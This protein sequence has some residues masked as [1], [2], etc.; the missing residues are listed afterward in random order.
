MSY[1][2]W[3]EHK[4]LID[5]AK[6]SVKLTTPDRKEVEFVAEPVVTAKGIAN[7]VKINQLGASQ[8]LE[9]LVVNEFPDVFPE[10]LPGMPPDRDIEFVIEL[11]PGTVPIYN[12]PFRMTI[13]ELAKLKEHIREL[14][15]K[16][17]IR[18]NSS[19]WGAPLIFVPMKD[20]TQ[21]LCVDYRA[22]N[23]V[24]VKNKYLLPRIDDLFDQLRGACVFSKINLRSGYH[25]LKVRECDIPKIAFVSRYGL[26]EFTVMSFGL[27]NASAYF[28]Y[29]MNKVFMVYLDKFI[30]VFINDIPVYSRNEEEHEGHLRLDLQKL[31]DHKLYAKLSKCEFWLKQV[32]F[33]GHVVLKGGISV[34]PSK[35]QDVLSWKAP[36]SVSDIRS[37]LGLAE[38]YQRFIEG[39]SRISKPMTELLKKDKQFKWTPTCEYSFQELKKRLTTAPVLVMPNMQDGRVVA[40]ASRQLRKHE[41]NYPTHDLEL[42][43][44][45]H[46]L[47][48]WRHYLMGKRCE[49]YMDHQSLKYI[50]TLSNLNL[51]QRR[52]LELIKDYD[53]GINYHLGKANV[54][55]DTLSRR[56]HVS[57]LVVDRMPFQ[58][59]EEFD[60]LNLRIV[61]NTEAT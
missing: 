61:T 32:A 44:V 3:I 5:C 55:A 11:K 22:L 56:S 43:V 39:F 14:L 59:C 35:V 37:F 49:L 57:Q 19:P 52:W 54:V 48:I 24:M 47:K 51:R 9:V 13:P 36:T 33:L 7:R 12:T 2:V 17:F 58:L 21:R 28:M 15:E 26:Y 41:V 46:A 30:V 60:K 53:L 31:R 1:L 34:D 6:K 8:G 27:T 25:Q 50:F 4:V 29:M 10:E 23:E 42:A 20:G 40:Y 16:G 38:Y 18:P 45:V